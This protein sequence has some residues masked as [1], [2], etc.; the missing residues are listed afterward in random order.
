MQ[1]ILFFSAALNFEGST[2]V[3]PLLHDEKLE[4]VLFLFEGRQEEKAFCFRW[5]VACLKL[6][7]NMF[8]RSEGLGNFIK[9]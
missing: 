4:F 3:V 8:V 5:A 9:P 2:F 6:E 7:G 1:V